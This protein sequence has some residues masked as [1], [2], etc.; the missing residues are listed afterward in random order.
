MMHTAL[1]LAVATLT[2]SWLIIST[3]RYIPRVEQWVLRKD[4]F[5]LIPQWNFFAPHPNQDD[6]Y[7]FYRTASGPAVGPWREVV[8]AP[9]RPLSA[10]LW[11]PHRRRHKALIDLCQ[12]MILRIHEPRAGVMLSLPYLLLL[13]FVAAEAG[14]LHDGGE[15][16]QFALGSVTPCEDPNDIGVI[17]SSA[18]HPR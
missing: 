16:V 15:R 13:N 12:A 1:V 6:Y 3:L 5:Y 10:L 14:R 8:I 4:L 18:F 17:F 2:G 11:N 7:L 9:T